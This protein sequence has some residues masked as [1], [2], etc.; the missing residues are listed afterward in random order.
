MREQQPVNETIFFSLDYDPGEE[1]YGKTG[2]KQKT[3]A[4]TFYSV[5]SIPHKNKH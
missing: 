2:E 5:L 1:N 3:C 4:T